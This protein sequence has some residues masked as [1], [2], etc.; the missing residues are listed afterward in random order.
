MATSST[1]DG[2]RDDES[3]DSLADALCG[4]SSTNSD[5]DVT[6]VTQS[7]D[8]PGPAP[9]SDPVSDV[10]KRRRYDKIKFYSVIVGKSCGIYSLW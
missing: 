1:V 4:L 8:P 9:I 6:H 5:L 7:A 10:P 2:H 3:V